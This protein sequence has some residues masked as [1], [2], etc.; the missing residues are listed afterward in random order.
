[1]GGLISSGPQVGGLAE[2]PGPSRGG[3]GGRALLER[4]GEGG[5]GSR[6][7]VVQGGEPP[8]PPLAGMNH[9]DQELQKC[10][11]LTHSVYTFVIM[12]EHR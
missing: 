2:W 7:G 9:I 10:T 8:P 1:M 4:R 6:G 5:R 11:T 3:R 12:Y